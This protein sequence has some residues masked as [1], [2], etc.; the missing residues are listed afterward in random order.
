MRRIIGWSAVAALVVALVPAPA[1]A[2]TDRWASWGPIEGASTNYTTVM[3]QQAPGFPRAQVATDSRATVQVA[4]GSSVFLGASTPPGAKYGSSRNQPYLVL[5]PKADAPTA[6]STTVYSFERPTPDTGW[7]FVLGDIDADQVRVAATDAQG[8]PVPAARVDSWFAGT[9]NH[10]GAP[11]LPTW[12]PTTST[13]LGSADARDTDGAS[14]WFEPDLRLSSLSLTF[15]RRAGFPVYQTWFV[16]RARPIGGA[17]TDTSVDD[18]CPVEDSVLSLVSPAGDVLATTR[19][20]SGGAY[21]FGEYATQA[22]YTV[23]VT[24]PPTCSVVGPSERAVSNRGNDNDEASR[25]NFSMR[26]IVPQPISGRV[27][28]G[29]GAPVPGVEVTVTRPDGST[30]SRTT[31]QAGA[32]LFDENPIGDGYEVSVRPPAGYVAGPAGTVRDGIDVD[33]DPITDQDFVVLSLPGVSGSVTAGGEALAGVLVNLT[34][35]D[36]AVS[37]ST[38]TRPDGTYDFPRTPPGAYTVT[39]QPPPGYVGT[40]TRELT[41]TDDD[42]TGQDFALGR[43]G[44]ISGRVTRTDGSPAADVE[45]RVDGPGGTSSTRTDSEGRYFVDD[46]PPGTYRLTVQPGAGAS[47]VGPGTLDA[48]ITEDGEALEDQDFV[49]GTATAPTPEPELT[50]ETPGPPADDTAADDD[51]AGSVPV[52]D[53][54]LP[55]SGGPPILWGLLGLVAVIG[56]GAVVLRSRGR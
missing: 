2:V 31:D 3:D 19:A 14:G 6:P 11:D 53:G 55:D 15:T 26:L 46:L 24:A 34:S 47:P 37:L 20:D 13:L 52:S 28:D 27:T 50:E 10:A 16:S 25:A 48:V 43:L 5:R 54:V 56:G 21:S 51:S 44:S 30:E 12:D 4:S 36:G 32:Y 33:D 41:V 7:A 45:I 39:I 23:R 8:R 49:L 18:R 17:I 9:F 38:S 29:D 42:V 1:S 40:T 22:G 35:S